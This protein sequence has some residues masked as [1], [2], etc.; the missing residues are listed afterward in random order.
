VAGVSLAL[1]P[2]RCEPSLCRAGKVSARL[3]SSL[4]V[5]PDLGTW[6]R[7]EALFNI[8][9]ALSGGWPMARLQPFPLYGLLM[10]LDRCHGAG[11]SLASGGI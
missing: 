4:H 11:L 5:L 10:V 3:G 6:P 1:L 9:L 7:S 2:G 8:T